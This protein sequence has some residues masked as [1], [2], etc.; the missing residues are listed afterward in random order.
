MQHCGGLFTDGTI[1]SAVDRIRADIELAAQFTLHVEPHAVLSV[2]LKTLANRDLLFLDLYREYERTE[3]TMTYANG[4]AIIDRYLTKI[5]TTARSMNKY[6]LTI[7]K[8]NLT[9]SKTLYVQANAFYEASAA[10]APAPA[11]SPARSPAP[12]LAHAD[13]EKTA[14]VAGSGKQLTCNAKD[15][16]KLVAKDQCEKYA[17]LLKIWPACHPPI[18]PNCWRKMLAGKGS[19]DI[20]HKT[21]EVTKYADATRPRGSGTAGA[22]KAAAL[23][24]QEY[25]QIKADPMDQID[26]AMEVQDQMLKERSV[27]DK[28]DQLN[29]ISDMLG[30]HGSVCQVSV[31]EE[32]ERKRHEDMYYEVMSYPDSSG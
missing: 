6:E 22:K 20:V 8:A 23:F 3:G 26:K 28:L 30:D 19:A 24:I 7:R 21:G 12:A 25:Q 18:C 5:E 17:K 1:K 16:V 10:P 27:S 9:E 32:Q 14:A 13:Q 11:R 2:L 31:M 15:C 29:A 4:V